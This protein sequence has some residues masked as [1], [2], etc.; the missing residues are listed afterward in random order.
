MKPNQLEQYKRILRA[1]AAVLVVANVAGAFFYIWTKFYNMRIIFPFYYKGHLL[2][3]AVYIILLLVFFYIYGGLKFGYLKS[4]N[5]ILSQFLAVICT[6]VVM[7]FQ[8]CLLAAKLEAIVPFV[9][10]T[11][12]DLLIIVFWSIV[13]SKV[14]KKLF[15]PR[16]LL[17]LYD[18]YEP[19]DMLNKMKSRKDRYEVGEVRKV[20]T[21]SQ[22]QL[23][24]LVKKYDAV[25]IY[26]LHSELRNKILKYCYSE[27]IRV[28]STSKIS[29]ILVKGAENIHLFDTPILLFRNYGLSFEQKV[30]KRLMDIVVSTIILIVTSPIMLLVAIAIKLYDGGPVMFRQERCTING[31]VFRIHK[32]RSMIVDAEKEGKAIPATDNDPRITPIGNFIRKTRI[33]ELP[34]MIDI[35]NGNMS[36]VGP[37]PERLE[38]VEKY[39]EEISEFKYRLKVK[40]GLTGYAQI[41]GKYNTTPYDKLKLDLMYIQNYSLLL[42]IRLI[43]MTVKIMFMK[44]STEGFVNEKEDK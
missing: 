27:S 11:M 19:T 15:P 33:D 42:D 25:L 1:I 44:E 18:E 24:V 4:S 20:W 26:D 32:F 16:R 34:Q 39:T 13:I 14:F 37:R 21:L 29:D 38:H 35:L 43:L 3:M 8:I 30:V 28:Y 22:D 23:K 40:G 36:L 7:Y 2:M 10:L 5:V 17:I 31:K 12:V 41:Y 9:Y 6:N